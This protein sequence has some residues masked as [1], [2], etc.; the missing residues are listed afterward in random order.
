MNF[1]TMKKQRNDLFDILLLI[2]QSPCN[3]IKDDELE[4]AK[5]TC[6]RVQDELAD[7]PETFLASSPPNLRPCEWTKVI[8][9][10]NLPSRKGWFHGIRLEGDA[11]FES[12]EGKCLHVDFSAIRFL[13]RDTDSTGDDA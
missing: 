8:R 9:G 4:S 3:I 2:I 11:C 5:R 13:D 7:S 12:E 10:K 1:E 6:L